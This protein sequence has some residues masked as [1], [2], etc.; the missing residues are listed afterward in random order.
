MILESKYQ[1]H[2]LQVQ[3]PSNID[4]EKVFLLKGRV[5]FTDMCIEKY[6]RRTKRIDFIPIQR[7]ADSYG[8]RPQ[9]DNNGRYAGKSDGSDLLINKD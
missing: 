5:N 7:S 9:N 3:N 2:L 8:L 4:E 1:K 6:N